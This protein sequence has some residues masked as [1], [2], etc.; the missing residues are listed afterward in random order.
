MKL[1]DNIIENIIQLAEPFVKA[2]YKVLNQAKDE[3]WP[4]VTDRDLILRSDMAYELGSDLNPGF[5]ATILTDNE[6]LVSSDE[7][8]VCGQELSEIADNQPYIRCTLVRVKEAAMGEGNALYNAI[9]KMEYIRYHFYPEGFM[10]RVS[11][12]KRK[13]S[14]RVSKE[15]LKRGLSFE[16]VGNRMIQ[17]FHQNE[18]VDAVKII[19]ITDPEFDYERM[20]AL[21]TESEAITETIDHML[22]DVKMDCD[23]CNLKPVCDEVEGLRELHFAQ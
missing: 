11:A 8:I 5:G 2:D 10:M 17:A 16:K 23:V 13:E 14:V 12:S 1:Y 6:A 3:E 9:R 18:A 21:L 4:L 20:E 19:Y 15:A 22:K 7:I